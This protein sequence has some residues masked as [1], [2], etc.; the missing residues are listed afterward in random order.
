[1]NREI[2]TGIRAFIKDSHKIWDAHFGEI[3]SAIRDHVHE[4]TLYSA[5]FLIFGYHRVKHGS[6][7]KLLRDID[8]LSEGLFDELPFH[9]RLAIIHDEM[10]KNLVK[11]HEEYTKVYNLRARAISFLP[12]QEVY[13]RAPLEQCYIK[14]FGKISTQIATS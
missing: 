1:M 13:V 9:E 10:K 2:L 3:A 12:D 6:A 5:H 14:F 7:Y 11:A 8:C 4:S